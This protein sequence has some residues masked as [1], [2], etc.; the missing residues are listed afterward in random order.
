MSPAILSLFEL[1]ALLMEEFHHGQMAFRGAVVQCR[2]TGPARAMHDMMLV[3][4]REDAMALC[5]VV[6]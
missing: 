5:V 1:C 6:W 4:C 2:P 3:L